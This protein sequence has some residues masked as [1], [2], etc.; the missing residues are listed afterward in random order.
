[1]LI[2]QRVAVHSG[3]DVRVFAGREAHNDV[4]ALFFTAAAFF[5][6][7]AGGPESGRQD[8]T[9]QQCTTCNF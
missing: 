9:V 5:G 7:R 4:S 6:V 3:T 2:Y 8:T 1:M